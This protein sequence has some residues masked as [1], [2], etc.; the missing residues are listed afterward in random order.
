[1]RFLCSPLEL[2]SRLL[3]VGHG[4][5]TGFQHGPGEHAPNPEKPDRRRLSPLAPV[6]RLVERCLQAPTAPSGE[7]GMAARNRLCFH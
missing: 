2:G 6:T 3:Y 1:M 7:N 5:I 4:G